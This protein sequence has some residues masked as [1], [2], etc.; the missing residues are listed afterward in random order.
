MPKKMTRREAGRLGGLRTAE[1]HG[2]EFFAKIGKEGG[3]ASSRSTTRKPNRS[4]R[5]QS[6]QAE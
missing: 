6:R 3:R 2:P 5:G 4:D 1:R